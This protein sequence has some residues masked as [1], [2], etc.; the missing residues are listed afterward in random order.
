MPEGSELRIGID[1]DEDGSFDRDEFD[2]CSDPAD[3]ASL[4]GAD[5]TPVEFL[6]LGRSETGLLLSWSPVGASWDVVRGDLDAGKAR[7]CAV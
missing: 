3:A 2:A 1:R 6:L 4:P 7:L 5:V